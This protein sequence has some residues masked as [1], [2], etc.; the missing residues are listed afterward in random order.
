MSGMATKV[1]D[2]SA[3]AAIA[4]VEPEAR[5]VSSHLQGARLA[6]PGLIRYEL[7]NICLTKLK[8]HPADES[9]ILARYAGLESTQIDTHAIDLPACIELGQRHRLSVYDA[10]YLW[11]SHFL[12]AELVTLDKKLAR[13]AAV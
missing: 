13:A 2:A 11:L 12:R 8:M 10:S 3:M 1:V 7:A 4:F 9:T 6:A 5:E